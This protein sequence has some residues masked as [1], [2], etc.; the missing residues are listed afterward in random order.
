MTKV[1]LEKPNVDAASKVPPIAGG[2]LNTLMVWF[3]FVRPDS[4]PALPVMLGP[5]K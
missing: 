3:S 4:D 2:P 5:F 1:M